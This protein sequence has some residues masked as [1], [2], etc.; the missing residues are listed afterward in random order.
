MHVLDI[1]CDFCDLRLAKEEVHAPDRTILIDGREYDRC[2]KCSDQMDKQLAGKGRSLTLH[3]KLRSLPGR[4][5]ARKE[6]HAA[7][8]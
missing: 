1:D 8:G 3:S 2:Q 6:N 7:I 4:E 5:I